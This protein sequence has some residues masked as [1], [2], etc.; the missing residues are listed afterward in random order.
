MYQ[1]LGCGLDNI[2]LRNGYE[3]RR[4]ESGS[5]VVWID[6]VKG[7]HRAIAQCVC[8]LARPL[9]AKEFKFLRKELDLSQRQV[10]T[11]LCIDEQTVSLWERGNSPINPAAEMLLRLLMK[12]TLSGNAEVKGALERL[13]EIDRKEREGAVPSLEFEMRQHD[14]RLAA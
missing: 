12:E 5:E 6:D 3:M 14:W 10:A 11:M 9:S 8:D 2:H 1:Y 13:C 7:L 4:T